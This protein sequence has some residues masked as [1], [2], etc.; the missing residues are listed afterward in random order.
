MYTAKRQQQT[1]S[2]VR[3]HNSQPTAQRQTLPPTGEPWMDRVRRRAYEIFRERGSKPGDA[4]SD[5]LQAERE[6]GRAT[7]SAIEEH[8]RVRGEALMRSS[9]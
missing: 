3:M 1:A 9:E 6:L 5:W 4:A 2:Q 8:L 7:H